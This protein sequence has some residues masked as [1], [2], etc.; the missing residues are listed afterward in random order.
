MEYAIAAK[1]IGRILDHVSGCED[2]PS[3]SS[4]LTAMNCS[5]TLNSMARSSAD[6]T[7]IAPE[8]SV[9]QAG[10]MQHA[11]VKE[12]HGSDSSL[13]NLPSKFSSAKTW[14]S[15]FQNQEEPLF[16]RRAWENTIIPD[17][18]NVHL[19]KQDSTSSSTEA[20]KFSGTSRGKL[21]EKLVYSKASRPSISDGIHSG[22]TCLFL[23]STSM[24]DLCT[25]FLCGLTRFKTVDTGLVWSPR[26][27]VAESSSS[28]VIIAE[29][30]GVNINGIRVEVDNHKASPTERQ[31]CVW[32]RS[33]APAERQSFCY[34]LVGEQC[35]ANIGVALFTYSI[36]LSQPDLPKKYA[37]E[38]KDRYLR[39]SA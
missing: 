17:L 8:D 32:R 16:C 33:V 5:S 3:P 11:S 38:E 9:S 1:R 14:I 31:T 12:S 25:Y 18:G 19:S 22:K 34:L 13:Q 37:K 21:E 6:R 24:K 23:D 27:D 7:I 28:Y 26:I 20:L 36:F 30:P 15:S 39:R 35:H 4:Q 29:L 2:V 10:F